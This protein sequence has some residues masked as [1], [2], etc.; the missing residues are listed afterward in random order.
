MTKFV[1]AGNFE[2]YRKHMEKM[3]YD[4]SEYVYVSDPIQLR[5]RETV[6]GFYIGTW[7][8]RPDIREIRNI[9]ATIKARTVVVKANSQQYLGTTASDPYT[10]SGSW[11]P[12]M[13]MI[14]KR[15]AWQQHDLKSNTITTI[16]IVD[17]V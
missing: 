14:K 13:I 17:D 2:Q 7:R 16:P 6:E 15:G 1:V 11:Q 10:H 9:I 4:P 3:R 5:G 12:S 8:D